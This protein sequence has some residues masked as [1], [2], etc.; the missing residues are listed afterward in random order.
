MDA[1]KKSLKGG[2]LQHFSHLF[3]G[4]KKEE[5]EIDQLLIVLESCQCGIE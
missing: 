4:H 2:Y 5:V 1:D 3:Q